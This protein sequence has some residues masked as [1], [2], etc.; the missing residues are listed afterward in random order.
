MT[1]LLT[2][3]AASMALLAAGPALAQETQQQSGQQQGGTTMGS[4]QGAAADFEDAEL[5]KFASAQ[6]G[7]NDIRD[8]YMAK[9]ES[10]G[11]QEQAQKLQQE[12][13]EKM[14]GVIEDEDLNVRTYNE[15]AAAYSSNPQTRERVDS[16]M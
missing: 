11:D 14:I 9:I 8:E 7:I 4:Q 5:Q 15:I 3:L 13:N 2:S 16:M 12:A 6:D 1:K 10:A